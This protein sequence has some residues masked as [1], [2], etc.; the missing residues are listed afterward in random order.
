M[1]Q[2][3]IYSNVQNV[4]PIG[5][6]NQNYQQN[7]QVNSEFNK[8]NPIQRQN[9]T[10]EYRRYDPTNL[11]QREVHPVIVQNMSTESL[12]GPETKPAL[13]LNLPKK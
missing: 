7:P 3:P 4:G 11:P 12:T 10:I 6:G 9:E 1:L 13:T 8:Y 2:Q 5:S